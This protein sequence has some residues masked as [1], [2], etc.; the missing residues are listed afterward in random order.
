MTTPS[1]WI[2]EAQRRLEVALFLYENGH[3][4]ESVSRAFYSL[5]AAVRGLLLQEGIETKTHGGVIRMLSMHFVIDGR[6]DK[7]HLTSYRYTLDRRMTVDYNV[8]LVSAEETKKCLD[9]ADAFLSVA[10]GLL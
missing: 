8:G 10:G 3:Y 4:P 1:Q 2:D 9:K 6:L 7:A 5:Y